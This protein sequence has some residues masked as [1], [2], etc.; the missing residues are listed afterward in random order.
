MACMFANPSE[1]VARRPEVSRC[2]RHYDDHLLLLVLVGRFGCFGPWSSCW[3][4]VEAPKFHDSRHM[5]VVRFSA[6][7]TGRHYPQEIFLVLISIRG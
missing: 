4:W 3:L 2:H 6:L 1:G 5:K 7:R